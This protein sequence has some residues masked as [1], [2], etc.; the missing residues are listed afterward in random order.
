MDLR[1]VSG[2]Q[3]RDRSCFIQI[4]KVLDRECLRARI[5][6]PLNLL[7]IIG[8]ADDLDWQLVETVQNFLTTLIVLRE[9]GMGLTIDHGLVERGRGIALVV[10]VHVEGLG[11]PGATHFSRA[12]HLLLLAQRSKGPMKSRSISFCGR[13]RL[14]FEQLTISLSVDGQSLSTP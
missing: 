11:D 13:E 1:R 6:R 8:V 2:S 14:E 4:L 12:D 5:Q 10:H 7:L 3:R 9:N